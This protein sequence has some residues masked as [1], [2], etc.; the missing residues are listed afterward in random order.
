MNCIPL[1]QLC[2]E[3]IYPF[4]IWVCSYWSFNP[5]YIYPEIWDLSQWNVEEKLEAIFKM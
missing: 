2:T 3:F 4:E 5:V 1:T